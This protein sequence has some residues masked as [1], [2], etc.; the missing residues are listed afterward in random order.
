[1]KRAWVLVHIIE[2]LIYQPWECPN[3][4]TLDIILYYINLL[5]FKAILFGSY[6]SLL[7]LS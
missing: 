6:I 5:I 2:L 3:S 7:E 4:G 1:M